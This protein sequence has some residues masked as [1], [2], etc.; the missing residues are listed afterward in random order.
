MPTQ[1]AA[2]DHH[3]S[4]HDDRCRPRRRRRSRSTA[5]AT[6]RCTRST[7]ST[8]SSS[9]SASPRSW[10]RPGSGKS[11]LLHC[12]AGL[13]RLTSGA[14]VPRRRRR[15]A[16]LSEKELTKVRRDKIGFVFQAF[17]LIPTLTALEN[18]TLPMALAGREPD[19]E[20]LDRVIDTVRPARPAVAPPVGALRWS[21]AARRGRPRAR[22]SRPGDHLRRR[23]DRQ[24]RLE[25]QRRDPPVHEAA[26]SPNSA[27]RS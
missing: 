2:S 20:W 14:G 9:G 19:Q 15:S 26:R 7:V 1:E 22:V 17:N 12:I 18:I 25:G 10:A 24:P 4:A 6:P 21:A 8:S 11:T 23:T 27:R 5:R 3:V 13:D 16:Q